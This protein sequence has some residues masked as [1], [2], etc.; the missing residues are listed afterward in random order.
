MHINPCIKHLTMGNRNAEEVKTPAYLHHTT[1]GPSPPS[2]GG[3]QGTGSPGEQHSC[4]SCVSPGA[5][6]A[7]APGQQALS[8][9]DNNG[10][11]YYISLLPWPW[12]CC[13]VLCSVTLG[14]FSNV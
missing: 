10:H 8:G 3:T 11:N 7:G 1:H 13:V 5:A 12:V 6:T 2:L 4:T 14:V 9:T